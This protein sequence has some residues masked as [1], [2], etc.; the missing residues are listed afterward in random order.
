[1]SFM[2]LYVDTFKDQVLFTW[3]FLFLLVAEERGIHSHTAEWV[4]NISHD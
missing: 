1:M 2:G 4:C 3:T